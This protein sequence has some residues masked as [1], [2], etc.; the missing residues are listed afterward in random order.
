MPPTL[1][2]APIGARV[3]ITALVAG[4][5]TPSRRLA[6]LGLRPG[7]TIRVVQRTAGGGRVVDI[8]GARVAL[9]RAVL[10]AI[11]IDDS[12]VR[13]APSEVRS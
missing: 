13:P 2:A 8:A 1:Y 11:T 7:T 6:E 9:G 12:A 10:A 3:V 4:A 5:E